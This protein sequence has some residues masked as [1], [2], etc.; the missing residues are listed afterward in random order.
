MHR[1][2]ALQE[3]NSAP[4]ITTNRPLLST[5]CWQSIGTIRV[6]P[7]RKCRESCLHIDAEVNVNK[8]S[9]NVQSHTAGRVAAKRKRN[10]SLKLTE[11]STKNEAVL[12]MVCTRYE[13][14]QQIVAARGHSCMPIPPGSLR[15]FREQYLVEIAKASAPYMQVIAA[16]KEQPCKLALSH[17]AEAILWQQSRLTSLLPA[18]AQPACIVCAMCMQGASSSACGRYVHGAQIAESALWLRR[19]LAK[20]LDDALGVESFMC[21]A[22]VLS[23][24]ARLVR[25]GVLVGRAHGADSTSPTENAVHVCECSSSSRAAPEDEFAIAPSGQDV[26]AVCMAAL[27]PILCTYAAVL[28]HADTIGAHGPMAA[29]L[30]VE[31]LLAKLREGCDS[32]SSALRPVPSKLLIQHAIMAWVE[33]DQL[34]YATGV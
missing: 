31:K 8:A 16:T 28:Y 25:E 11:D 29:N 20:E 21:K 5:N 1:M 27:A 26:L 32:K 14:I 15:P 22:H 34:A 6:E 10:G 24:L 18:F 12:D 23:E 33:H 19:L 2:H 3:A 7:P 13:L 4:V 30:F 17:T 9:Q